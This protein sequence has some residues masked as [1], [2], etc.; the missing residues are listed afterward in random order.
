MTLKGQGH[1]SK[2]IAPSDS[3]TYKADLD[4]KIII[5]KCLSSKVKVKDVFLHNSLTLKT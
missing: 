2:Q 5:L 1:S 3:L 4:A